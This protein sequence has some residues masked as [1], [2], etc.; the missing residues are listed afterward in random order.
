[1]YCKYLKLTNGDNIMVTTE[2]SCNDLKTKDHINV[3]DPVLI[4]SVRFPRGRMIVETYIM[5]PWL[6][7]SKAGVVKIPVHSIVV[8]TD[9]QESA[10]EQYKRYLQEAPEQEPSSMPAS[11]DEIDDLINHVFNG[12]EEEA[13]EENHDGNTDPRTLH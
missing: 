13:E 1:M 5:Q 3:M 6:K 7:M 11:G 4:D 10:A 8:A 9:V 12:D 2:D